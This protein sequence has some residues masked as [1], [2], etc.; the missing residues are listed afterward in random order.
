MSFAEK[1]KAL[2]SQQDEVVAQDYEEKG[3]I[4]GG[5]KFSIDADSIPLSFVN[6]TNSVLNAKVGLNS[7]KIPVFSSSKL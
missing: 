5:K 1:F 2:K 3:S 7:N 4:G 6:L